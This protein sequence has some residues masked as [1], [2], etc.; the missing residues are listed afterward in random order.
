M[1]SCRWQMDRPIFLLPQ[2]DL[3][4]TMAIFHWS[5]LAFN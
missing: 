1:D 3:T 2:L 4:S 5:V